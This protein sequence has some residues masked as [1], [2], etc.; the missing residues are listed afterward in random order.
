MKAEIIAIGTE[1]LMGD[2]VNTNATWISKAL[3]ELGVDVY[4]HVTVGDNPPRIR[5]IIDQAVERADLLIFT[6]GLGPTVDDLTIATLAE[7]FQTPLII[8]PDSE[9][10]I[11]TMFIA[12]NMPMS[13]TNLKQAQKPEGAT[14]V[15]NPLG[16]APGIAWDVSD[17]TG[18]STYLLTFPGVPKELYA[19][20]PAGRAFIQAKQKERGETLEVLV[21]QSM[22][23]F[24]IG[25]SKLGKMLADLMNGAN[26]TV[27]P[28][29][30]NAEVRIRIVAKAP[31]EAKA[32]ALITPIKAEILKRCD[33]YYYGTDDASLEQCVAE[34]LI[35]KGF[36][37]GVAESCTGGLISSR[38]TDIPGSSAFTVG[39]VVTYANEDKTAQ[40]G[41]RAETLARHG[42]VSAEVAA[43]MAQGVLRRG[44]YDVAL[45]VTGIAGPD[46]GKEEKPVGLAYIGIAIRPYSLNPGDPA[47]LFVKKVRVNAKYGRKDIKHWFSQYA[48]THTL[49]A[50]RGILETDFDD[51]FA[52][53]APAAS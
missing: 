26:P 1:L 6:G 51:L 52:P 5:K 41:V 42:A 7:H 37:L 32:I 53:V 44:D 22:H 17:K 43:E 45:S 48:L 13:P 28:Y 24:G 20:W 38:L 12:R 27:A 9:Q 33:A 23:F 11:R 25:E 8:D 4:H 30:G 16:T 31:D 49:Q 19:M 2:V 47:R 18:K 46:G 35:A 29:V 39:N 34:A 50:L 40:L 3:A 15:P 10:T 36:K 21:A 14:T